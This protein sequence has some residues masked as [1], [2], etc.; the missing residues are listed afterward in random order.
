MS[1]MVR[2]VPSVTDESTGAA[3]TRRREALGYFDRKDFAPLVPIAINTLRKVELNDPSVDPKTV[4]RV[5]AKLVEL[6]RLHSDDAPDEIVNV[7]EVDLGDGRTA[8]AT[9]TGSPEGVAEAVA[10]LVRKLETGK[11]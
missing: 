6:E 3:I 9:F 2:K 8:R 5:L 7:L 4:R 1:S 11:E 10:R